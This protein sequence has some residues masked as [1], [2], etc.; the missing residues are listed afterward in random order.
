MIIQQDLT[1]RQRFTARAT[2][3]AACLLVFGIMVLFGRAWEQFWDAQ[4]LAQGAAGTNSLPPG[5]PLATGPKPVVSGCTAASQTGGTFAGGM[6]ITCST[7]APVL[8]FPF[9]APTGWTCDFKDETTPADSPAQTA[10]TTTTATFASTSTGAGD[11][12]S[13]KCAAY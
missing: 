2:S 3:L 4:A 5:F 1:P 10:H 9:P 6:A 7:Q 13:F 8:T 11:V 12:A